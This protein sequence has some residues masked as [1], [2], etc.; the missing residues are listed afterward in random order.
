[1][2]EKFRVLGRCVFERGLSAGV[3]ITQLAFRFRFRFRDW[4]CPVAESGPT[5]QNYDEKRFGRGS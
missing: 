3:T 2:V 1:M 4:S 5:F